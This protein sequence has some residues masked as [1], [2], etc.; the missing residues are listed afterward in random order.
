MAED[1]CPAAYEFE[2]Q[3]RKSMKKHPALECGYV[4]QPIECETP[5]LSPADVMT[6][7]AEDEWLD[8]E[9]LVHRLEGGYFRDD[10]K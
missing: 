4:V 1:T 6:D 8:D 2:E 7:E 3:R 5:G 9:N 10:G